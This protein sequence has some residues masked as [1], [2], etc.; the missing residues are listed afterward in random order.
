MTVAPVERDHPEKT[1]HQP[2]PLGGGTLPHL[3]LP[4]VPHAGHIDCD[5][6]HT[7]DHA[8]G[9]ATTEK[10]LEPLCRHDHNVKH[11]AGWTLRRTPNGYTWTS[12]LGHE[13]NTGPDPP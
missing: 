5:L 6:D 1:D 3:C 13:Y 9:G 4:R 7:I 2:A 11:H 12:R 8:R 10:N